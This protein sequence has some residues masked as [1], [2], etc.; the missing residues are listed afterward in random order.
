VTL[1][2]ALEACSETA[3]GSESGLQIFL[4][5]PRLVGV[6]REDEFHGGAPNGRLPTG[7]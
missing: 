3:L 6:D 4:G 7:V 2:P 1:P 5:F